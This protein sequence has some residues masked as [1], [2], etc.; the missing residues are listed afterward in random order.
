MGF[1]AVQFGERLDMSPFVADEKAKSD[2]EYELF[3]VLMHS[4]TAVGGHYFAYIKPPAQE[5]WFEFN[6]S[7]VM[8]LTDVMKAKE[9]ARLKLAKAREKEKERERETRE[10]NKAAELANAAPPTPAGSGSG[11]GGGSTS[12]SASGSG[13]AAAKS[14]EIKTTAPVTST[15]TA[16][17]DASTP[18]NASATAAATAAVL[19]QVWDRSNPLSMAYGGVVEGMSAYML[20]YH[21]VPKKSTPPTLT[22]TD[23]SSASTA[24]ASA[25]SPTIPVPDFLKAVIDVCVFGVFDRAKI[26]SN[27]EIVCCVVVM[28]RCCDVDGCLY[29]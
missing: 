17:T 19:A 6:D 18:A 15:G 24:A 20:M 13:S 12:G 8:E 29:M 4:G 1:D 21:R 3:A 28:L 5:K 23:G 14:E 22:P 9:E 26:E 11:S 7:N 25:T 2:A 27:T 16:A 10:K